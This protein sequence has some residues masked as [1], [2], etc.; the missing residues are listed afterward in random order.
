MLAGLVQLPN[1]SQPDHKDS[2]IRVSHRQGISCVLW[3]HDV[4]LSLI[5]PGSMFTGLIQR[6]G[7]VRKTGRY[8]R[9]VRL[10]IE[11]NPP[12]L[13]LEPG[14]SIAIDGT[15]LTVTEPSTGSFSADVSAETL[16]RTTLGSRT[17][18]DHINLERALRLSDRLGGHLVTG[19]I[20]CVGKIVTVRPEGAFSTISI[21]VPTPHLRSLI[22]KGSVA[23]NGVSLTISALDGDRFSVAVIPATLAATTLGSLG[24]GD[25]VN[26]E[27]DIIGKYVEKLLTGRKSSQQDEQ[28]LLSLLADSSPR[29]GR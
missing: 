18:G 23:V 11:M 22:S 17:N 29:T 5:M 4:F 1:H 8:G 6:I 20:D 16:S 9:A 2:R 13:A 25:Q 10:N 28:N 24:A 12:F 7:T 19:H 14:E 26:I 21:S 15:C 27:T 3:L